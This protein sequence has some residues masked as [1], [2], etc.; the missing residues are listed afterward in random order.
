[1]RLTAGSCRAMHWHTAG[2][3][4]YVLYG[5][6]RV[7]GMQPDGERFIDDVS[8]GDLWIF[9][10]GHPHSIQGPGPDGRNFC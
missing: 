3:W 4:A 6:A 8:E 7:T 2:E 5:N 9:P 1:M 10:A